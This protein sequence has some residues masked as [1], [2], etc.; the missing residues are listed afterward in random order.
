[1]DKLWNIL[2]K[3]ATSFEVAHQDVYKTII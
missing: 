3:K 1:M 2:F